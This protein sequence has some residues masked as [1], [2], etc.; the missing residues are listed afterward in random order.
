MHKTFRDLCIF[1]SVLA[2]AGV[3]LPRTTIPAVIASA[4]SIAVGRP[5]CIDIP[6]EPDHVWYVP[7]KSLLDLGAL[8]MLA[9]LDD[10]GG[11]SVFH[12]V[13]YVE[14]GED[15]ER[16]NWS[17]RQMRFMLIEGQGHWPL[18]EISQ[19]TRRPDFIAHLM[20]AP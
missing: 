4:Q 14:H 12:A 9:H 2:V 15:V 11:Y 8:R 3:I 18:N 7:A 16:Y 20:G 10:H 1:V 17:Y 13:M 19:C 5:Y 6:R